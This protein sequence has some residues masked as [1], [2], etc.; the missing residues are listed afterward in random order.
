MKFRPGM[1]DVCKSAMSIAGWVSTNAPKVKQGAKVCV[2]ARSLFVWSRLPLEVVYVA[3]QQAQ[4]RPPPISSPVHRRL[5]P[6]DAFERVAADSAGA[7][8]LLQHPLA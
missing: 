2:S 8:R 3:S 6:E 7:Y 1:R 5:S 4:L